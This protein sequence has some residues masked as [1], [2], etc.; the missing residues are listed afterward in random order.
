MAGR[1]GAVRAL[2]RAYPIVADHRSTSSAAST[3]SGGEFAGLRAGEGV[4]AEIDVRRLVHAAV[5]DA[6]IGELD[7]GGLNTYTVDVDA[8]DTAEFAE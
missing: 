3:S 6:P 4:V 8:V 5:V 7:C 1:G 2:S